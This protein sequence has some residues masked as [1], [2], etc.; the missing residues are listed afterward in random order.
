MNLFRLAEASAIKLGKIRSWRKFFD[1]S[2]KLANEAE[3]LSLSL[4]AKLF[5]AQY[6][7]NFN[8]KMLNLC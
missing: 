4:Y 5:G 1:P 2:K 3:T 8:Y 6:V 7:A